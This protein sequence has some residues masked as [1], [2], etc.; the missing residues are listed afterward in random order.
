[1]KSYLKTMPKEPHGDI[2]DKKEE[3]NTQ[4]E[5]IKFI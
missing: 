5:N 4:I 1:M 3:D 2:I